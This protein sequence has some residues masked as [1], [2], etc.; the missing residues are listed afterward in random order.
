MEWEQKIFFFFFSSFYS[1]VGYVRKK[2]SNIWKDN[3]F[4]VQLPFTQTNSIPAN[5]NSARRVCMFFFL[6]RNDT[7]ILVYLLQFL[8]VR[9]RNTHTLTYINWMQ[10]RWMRAGSR[11]HSPFWHF[12]NAIKNAIINDYYYEMAW[13]ICWSSA[14]ITL[15][16]IVCLCRTQ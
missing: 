15:M 8:F 2:I 1:S 10:C 5:S 14:C 6:L 13:C 7:N 4:Y 11:S 9:R 12:L 16:H 3:N